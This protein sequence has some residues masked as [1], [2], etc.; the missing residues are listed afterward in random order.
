MFR[1]A[2]EF[3]DVPLS[4]PHVLYKLPGGVGKS[5][6]FLTAQ[7][8]AESANGFVEAYMSAL[9]IQQIDEVLLQRRVL[10]SFL[11]VISP[12]SHEVHGEQPGEITKKTANTLKV[13]SSNGMSFRIPS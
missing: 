1:V 13:Y 9:K 12:R 2:T 3:E 7:L 8:V 5:F 11:A 4:N 6:C 10:H